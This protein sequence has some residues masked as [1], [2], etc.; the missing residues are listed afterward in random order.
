LVVPDILANA[1]GVTVSYF[2]WVQNR[3]GFY[4]TLDE[5]HERLLRMMRKEFNDV[6]SL[7]LEQGISMRTAGYAHALNRL[8]DAISAQ[9]TQSFFSAV[10]S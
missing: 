1:G 6:Y 4:W 5:V 10:P 2:E 7:M 8:G 9:G 3:N